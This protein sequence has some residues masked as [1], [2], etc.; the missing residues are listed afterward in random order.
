[1]YTKVKNDLVPLDEFFSRMWLND[2]TNR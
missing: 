2:T 1:M